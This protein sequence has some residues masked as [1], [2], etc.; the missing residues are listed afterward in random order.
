MKHIIM[1]GI[2]IFSFG[3]KAQSEIS[4]SDMER[5]KK[6]SD[7]ASKVMD[8]RQSGMSLHD[9]LSRF[10]GGGGEVFTSIVRNQTMLAFEYPLYTLAENKKRESAR[11]ADQM[12]S[13]CIVTYTN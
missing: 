3:C 8:L 10:T 11:F 9:V 4:S 13:H 12:F 2:L 7:W 5:C 1:A 6:V